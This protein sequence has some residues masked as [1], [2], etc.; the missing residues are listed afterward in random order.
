MGIRAT[1]TLGANG[2]SDAI[3]WPGG[4]GTVK[5]RGTFSTATFG[6]NISMDGGTSWA[7]GGSTVQLTAAGAFNFE[8]SGDECFIQ[9]E[10]TGGGTP[11]IDW[12]VSSK[13]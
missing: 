6:M 12:W 3:K 8:V 7:T 9:F 5:A 13:E 11:D 1:G 2:T 4:V 10:T